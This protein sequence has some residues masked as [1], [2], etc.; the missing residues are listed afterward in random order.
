MTNIRRLLAA[1]AALPLLAFAAPADAAT[2][3][4]YHGTF[5]GVSYTNCLG[6]T[7]APAAASGVW[8]ISARGT[9]QATLT[10]NIFV[11]GSHHVSFGAPVAQTTVPGATVAVQ[12]PTLAGPLVVSLTGQTLSYSIT[13]YDLNGLQC[14]S[15]LYTG[16]F[17]H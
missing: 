10:V 7:P 6:G 1:A 8:T 16:L 5:T 13:P 9:S 3:V 11:N 14:D 4:T 15:V 12:V 2:A 17:D